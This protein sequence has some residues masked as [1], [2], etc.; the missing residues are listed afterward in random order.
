[1]V[2]DDTEKLLTYFDDEQHLV[3]RLGAAVVSC[4]FDL[5]Q[6]LRSKIMRRASLV[7]DDDDDKLFDEHLKKF[8]DEHGRRWASLGER[9][10][11]REFAPN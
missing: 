7:L 9:S 2:L 1:M 4:W 10:P 8:I 5:P 11:A 3:R 6:H